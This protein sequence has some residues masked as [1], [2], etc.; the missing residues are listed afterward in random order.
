MV[1]LALGTLTNFATNEPAYACLVGG[2]PLQYF[3]SADASE[4][5]AV[6]ST[7]ASPP[8]CMNQDFTFPT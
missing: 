5:V 8:D 4:Y 3:L 2:P 6:A 1:A 7:T